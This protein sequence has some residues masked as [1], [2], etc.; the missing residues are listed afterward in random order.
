V[1]KRPP[2]KTCGGTA[3]CIRNLGEPRLASRSGSFTPVVR[4][5]VRMGQEDRCVGEPV[6]TTWRR[7]S[8]HGLIAPYYSCVAVEVN[9]VTIYNPL[10]PSSDYTYHLIPRTATLHFT[11]RV[12]LRVSYDSHNKQRLF[13]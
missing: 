5:P 3:P 12:Y 11:H 10:K 8:S 1:T 6:L 9:A 7:D 13:P 2:T 4:Y